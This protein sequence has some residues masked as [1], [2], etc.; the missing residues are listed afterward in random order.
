MPPPIGGAPEDQDFQRPW[1][2]SAIVS[3]FCF[4]A[5]FLLLYTTGIWRHVRQWADWPFMFYLAILTPVLLGFYVY[6]VYRV[7]VLVS[8]RKP[9]QPGNPQP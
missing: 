6:G 1:L 8:Q 3:T 9:A 4:G 5:G 7:V 2:I